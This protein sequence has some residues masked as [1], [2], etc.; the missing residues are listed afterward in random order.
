MNPKINRETCIGCG[1]CASIYEEVYEVDDAEG[2][3]SV[4]ENSEHFCD[5]VKIQESI[6]ACPTTS[7][8]L[9]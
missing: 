6:L 2:K 9:E 3:A 7:I 8:S 5:T 1:M 4:K